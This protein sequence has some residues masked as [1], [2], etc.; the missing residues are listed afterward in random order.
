MGSSTLKYKYKGNFLCE[1][2][3][4]LKIFLE[5]N[6]GGIQVK[7]TR[8]WNTQMKIMVSWYHNYIHMYIPSK[9]SRGI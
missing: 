2:Q 4:H 7:Q 9:V 3:N 5:I 8:V 6:L 1:N